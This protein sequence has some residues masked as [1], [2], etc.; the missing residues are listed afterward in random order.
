MSIDLK[1]NLNVIKLLRAKSGLRKTSSKTAG[2]SANGKVEISLE[3]NQIP[4]FTNK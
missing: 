3:A 2:L 1:K 4:I